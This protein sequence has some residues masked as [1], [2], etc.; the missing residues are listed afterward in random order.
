MRHQR[1]NPDNEWS[2]NVDYTFLRETIIGFSPFDS[3]VVNSV[4]LGKHMITKSKCF[5]CN[6]TRNLNWRG[7]RM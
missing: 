3:I 6:Y 7:S 2:Y 5:T 1:T 4:F